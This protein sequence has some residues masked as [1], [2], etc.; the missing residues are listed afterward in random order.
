[1]GALKRFI[2]SNDFL[3]SSLKSCLLYLRYT[4]SLFRKDQYAS[5]TQYQIDSSFEIKEKGYHCWFG[6]YDK[7]PIN[8]SGEYVVYGRAKD[9]SIPGQPIDICIYDIK[10]GNSKKIGETTTWN[11]QQGCMAQWIGARIVSFNCYNSQSKKYVTRQ[12]SI[13]NP[14]EIKELNRAAYYYNS[15]FS[16]FLSLNFYRLD[17]FAKGYGYPYDVD[18]MEY[19]KDGV[20]E[21]EVGSNQEKLIL[22]LQTIIDYEAK[23]YKDLLH[24][25]NHVAYTPDEQSIIFI[26]RWQ[27]KGGE[28][29]SRLL[30]YNLSTQSLETLLDNGHVSHYCWKDDNWLLIFATNSMEQKGYM[31]VNIKTKE[32]ILIEGLPMED[33]H[34]S[35]SNGRD[36]VLTDTYPSLRRYQYLFMFDVATRQLYKLDK[37]WSPFRYFNDERCD[38]HP[39]W[40]YDN[41]YICADNT[42]SGYRGLKIFKL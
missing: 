32:T 2:K 28:F 12:V 34:P 21:V 18:S 33:G 26:H 41:K 1:M 20:W 8:P 25:V 4:K 30:K 27:Q 13:D 35:Y 42:S 38:L 5:L 29:K 14:N 15:S 37:L 40:S 22:S 9:H 16:K 39:R 3:F 11:W 6:Y 19:L 10:S 36:L 17:L 7:S 31:E 24:Y 23:D